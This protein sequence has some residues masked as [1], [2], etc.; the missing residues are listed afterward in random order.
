MKKKIIFSLLLFGSSSISGLLY[1]QTVLNVAAMS[2]TING[3]T[4]S[5]SMG[6]MALVSTETQ[7]NYTI[8]Q[9]FLQPQIIFIQ[10]PM[11]EEGMNEMG[12]FSKTIKLYPNPTE[13]ILHIE[14]E[15]D[16]LDE[17]TIQLY[18]VTGRLLQTKHPMQGQG[19]STHQID[20]GSYANGTYQLVLAQKKAHGK[21]EKQTFN[22]Q[23]TK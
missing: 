1:G 8:T 10:D 17:L 14:I 9:G 5:N 7:A 3:I 6:E 12:M 16:Q 4:F 18:D 22:I 15:S 13:A 20:L 21:E 11:Q 23:K 2:Q 19:R